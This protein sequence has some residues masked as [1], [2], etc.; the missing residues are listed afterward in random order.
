LPLPQLE[1]LPAYMQAPLAEDAK[2]PISQELW[3]SLL[4]QKNSRWICGPGDVQ[5]LFRSSETEQADHIWTI[6][7]PALTFAP[8]DS[9][10]TENSF[11]SFWDRNIRQMLEAVMI[12]AK[13]FRASNKQTSIG[14]LEPDFA[15]L[16]GG[17]CTFRGEEKAPQYSGKHPKAELIEKL[18]WAYDPAPYILG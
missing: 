12:Q 17:N 8:P 13:V 9:D 3:A 6:V 14:L 16:V 4:L 2:I 15:L 11:H 5:R 1:N 10:S 18:T 7:N